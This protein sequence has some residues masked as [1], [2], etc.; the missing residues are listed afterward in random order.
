VFAGGEAGRKMSIEMLI[1][2]LNSGDGGKRAAAAAEI[3]RRGKAVL[4]DLKKAGAKQV[5]PLE[6]GIGTRRVDMVYSVL[7]G[8]PANQPD[9]RAG[10][11][12]HSFGLHVEKGTTAEDIRKICQK[13]ECT[14][15]GK[16][17]VDSS[18]S[19]YLQKGPGPTLEAVIQMILSGEPKVTTI[20]LNYFEG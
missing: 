9:A 10:Y 8:F 20:N 16:F 5:A 14:L 12:T 18:P 6:G 1:N 11:K 7:E 19:C 15:A 13:Y 4:P 17:R 3:F 2:D